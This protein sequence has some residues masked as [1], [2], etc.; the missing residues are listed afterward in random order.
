MKLFLSIIPLIPLIIIIPI[1]KNKI[2]I[3][4]VSHVSRMHKHVLRLPNKWRK[5]IPLLIAIQQLW[6]VDLPLPITQLYPHWHDVE[7]MNP[8]Y[9][10]LKSKCSKRV[11]YQMK[12]LLVTLWKMKFHFKICTYHFYHGDKE[13]ICF[14][15][16]SDRLY[17]NIFIFLIEREYGFLDRFHLM[18]S[19]CWYVFQCSRK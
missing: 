11:Y 17:G 16:F 3:Y 13:G 5:N 2:I 7:I 6:V 19:W 10:Y 12:L 1:K 8:S 15:R 9:L 14:F 18:N 4:L